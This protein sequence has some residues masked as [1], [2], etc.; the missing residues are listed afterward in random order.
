[1]RIRIVADA[2]YHSRSSLGT[3]PDRIV[4]TIRLRRPSG[5]TGHRSRGL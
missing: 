2:A 4:W 1:M 3:L 5:G